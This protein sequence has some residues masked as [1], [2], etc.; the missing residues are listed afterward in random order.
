MSELSKPPSPTSFVILKGEFAVL[1][2]EG[3]AIATPNTTSGTVMTLCDTQNKIIAMAHFDDETNLDQNIEKIFDSLKKLGGD[4][5]NLKCNIMSKNA[6][7]ALERKL[8]SKGLIVDNQTWSG[9]HA[10]NVLVDSDGGIFSDNSSES[11]RKYFNQILFEKD[12][13]KRLA[14]AISGQVTELERREPPNSS[15]KPLAASLPFRNQVKAR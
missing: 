7:L 2:G 15:V 11:M 8:S 9:N 14:A 4:V 10:Y 3:A 12:G 6:D 1:Q 5:E 13:E